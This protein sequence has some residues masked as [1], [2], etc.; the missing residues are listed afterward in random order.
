MHDRPMAHVIRRA[1]SKTLGPNHQTRATAERAARA[2]EL[3]EHLGERVARARAELERLEFALT[4]GRAGERIFHAARDLDVAGAA[5]RE[6][7]AR[8]AGGEGGRPYATRGES[9]FAVRAALEAA[10]THGPDLDGFLRTVR[11]LGDRV[12]EAADVVARLCGVKEAG[13]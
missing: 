12:H 4:Q 8:I 3:R 13:L 2:A 6:L 9:L 7:A 11:V 5:V 10:A 1:K